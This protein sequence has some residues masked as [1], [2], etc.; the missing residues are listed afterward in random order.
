[1]VDEHILV[2]DDEKSIQ[3]SLQR[4]LEDEGFAVTS[5]E[6]GETALEKMTK[7]NLDLVMLDVWLPGIDGLETL[8]RIKKDW[9]GVPVIM[10]SGH[11]TIETA[12]TATK[13]G[14]YDFI[15]KPLSLEKVLISVKHALEQKKLEEENRALRQ[16]VEKKYQVV[17]D[18]SA[19]VSLKQLISTA[20]PSNS[21]VLIYGENGTGKELVARAIHRQSLRL[22]GP[23]VE[24]NCAAIPEDLIES[25]LFGH[26]K[27]SF[28][29]ASEQRRGKFELADKG[30]LFLDEVG[31][32]SMKTQA[33]VLRV[34]EESA[35]QRVGGTQL[36]NTD[37]RVIAASNK[38]LDE[39]INTGQF[40]EDLFYRLNVIPISVPPLRER[41]QD[42]PLLV[43]YFLR[44]LSMEN[45]KKLKKIDAD[46]LEALCA[47]H[48]PGN[49]R[50][51]KNIV[52]RLVIMIPSDTIKAEDLP[53]HLQSQN[54]SEPRLEINCGS[55]RDAR[56]SFEKDYIQRLLESNNWNISKTAE[57]LKIGRNNLYNKIKA[58]K[59]EQQRSLD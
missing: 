25:E 26:E 19:M 27:G 29:G 47:Y 53:V 22:E 9:K 45:G 23:F 31:D 17:G 44:E 15:E 3:I 16:K 42:I 6:D 7:Q 4:I 28:T 18:S 49:V 12:V 35:F 48:W 43:E 40:R 20:A 13:M 32:M 30:T 37:T 56:N 57:E 38:Q 21:R 50:E 5:V 41:G 2:V 8:S 14:A 1:M 39:E 10:I 24:V 46:A 36:I 58:Y 54:T 59:L 11:G 33:K 55:L 51:L 34:L 52:E